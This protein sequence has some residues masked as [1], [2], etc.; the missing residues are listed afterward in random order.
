M[1]RHAE[2]LD[3][4]LS[5][6]RLIGRDNSL[7]NAIQLAEAA[8]LYPGNPLPILISGEQ[9]TG[10]S[11]FA[12]MAYEFAKAHKVISESEGAK[13]IDCASY[14]DRDN[15]FSEDFDRYIG[16]NLLI[17]HLEKLNPIA[18]EHL[19]DKIKQ[20]N[21]R[22]LI[23]CTLGT[24]DPAEQS[25]Y[26]SGMFSV[27]IQMPSLKERSIEERKELVDFFL[28]TEAC[29]MKM[30]LKANSEL[31]YCLI[32]YS[33]N[34]VNVGIS[35]RTKCQKYLPAQDELSIQLFHHRSRR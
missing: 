16:N 9:G 4:S 11:F 31:L 29:R 10:K 34:Y 17:D 23:I 32:L 8:I 12:E 33:E 26:L 15:Q 1:I 25:Q 6:S 21:R 22:N 35:C 19:S 24:E 5:F 13:K 28:N 14:S 3:E 7:K 18:L 30:T 2:F 20:N 27:N